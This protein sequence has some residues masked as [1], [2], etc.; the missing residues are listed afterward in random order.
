MGPCPACWIGEIFTAAM[1]TAFQLC[2]TQ[3]KFF[4]KSSKR[5][6]PRPGRPLD[7]CGHGIAVL[8]CGHS[9][10]NT[11]RFAPRHCHGWGLSLF[12]VAGNFS[13][14]RFVLFRRSVSVYGKHPRALPGSSRLVARGGSL[15]GGSG[16]EPSGAG[17]G[18]IYSL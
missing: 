6:M 2:E 18:G 4:R 9:H 7:I 12:S 1:K 5:R 11:P 13:F 15:R 3:N 14:L 10:T 17:E 16:L 8:P